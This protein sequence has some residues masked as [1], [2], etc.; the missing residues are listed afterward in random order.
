MAGFG[1]LD[2]VGKGD[3]FHKNELSKTLGRA[4]VLKLTPAQFQEGKE[5]YYK[6]RLNTQQ[7]SCYSRP[8]RLTLRCY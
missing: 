2:R 7:V 3:I 6:N 1:H 8:R 4:A 5:A